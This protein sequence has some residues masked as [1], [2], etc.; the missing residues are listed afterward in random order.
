MGRAP[1][2][3][4]R[5]REDRIV[6]RRAEAVADDGGMAGAEQLDWCRRSRPGKAGR[7]RTGG[8]ASAVHQPLHVVGLVLSPHSSRCSPSSHRS[9]GRGTGS[10]GAPAPSP[11]RR[12][13]TAVAGRREQ[14]VELLGGEA[15]QTQV[16]AGAIQLVQLGGEQLV[17]PPASSA[18]CCRRCGRRA[19]APASGAPA[20]SPA[21]RQPEGAPPGCGRAR[22]SPRARVDQ[23]RHGPAELD[24]RGRDL[25][26]LVVGVRARIAR[27]RTQL[28]DPQCSMLPGWKRRSVMKALVQRMRERAH[29]ARGLAGVFGPAPALASQPVSSGQPDNQ[30]TI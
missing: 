27:V 25:G 8:A 23:H 26:D 17:V 2:H 19:P 21:P 20:G 6:E 9:P 11:R 12:P 30:L 4:P 24:Q 7:S 5:R 14:L 29:E 18:S 3:S 10:P 22:R 28:V 16:E 15:G 1:R 13:F